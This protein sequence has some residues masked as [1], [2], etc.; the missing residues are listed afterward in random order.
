MVWLEVRILV[1]S[2]RAS[3]G[4]RNPI[5]MSR[6]RLF[7]RQAWD[8]N[9]SIYE[10]I[11]TMP[12]NAQLALGHVERGA[13]QALHHAGRALPHRLWTRVDPCRG[14]GARSGSDRA[15]RQGGGGSADRGAGA[16]RLVL[17]AVR[18][19]AAGIRADTA[20]AGLSP[21][22]LVSTRH[23]LWGALRSAARGAAALLLDLRGGGTRHPRSCP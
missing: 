12:F 17:Q 10:V 8:K 16:A 1:M 5:H 20:L 19:H 23:R 6:T 18:H 9:A 15:I 21:L 2:G 13:L 22:R 4:F 7:S 11:R 3:F 14:E